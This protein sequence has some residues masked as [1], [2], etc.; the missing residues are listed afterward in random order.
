MLPTAIPCK[1]EV[2]T[3]LSAFWFEQF[4][5][6]RHHLIELIEDR[7][8]AGLESLS[9]SAARRSMLVRKTKVLPIEC[10]VRGYLA[11]SG[12]KEYQKTQSVCGVKLPAGLRQCE[13]LPEPI[14]TPSTKAETGHDENI[15]YRAGLPAH[16]RSGD[17]HGPR[18]KP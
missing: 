7:A 3:R 15:S 6:V 10:V 16:Q 12:W 11:G 2:L 14:F 1:G 5:N 13:R 4:R 18:T 9:R 17:A 8:P